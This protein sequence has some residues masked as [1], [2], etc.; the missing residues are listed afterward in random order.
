[1]VAIPKEVL[2]VLKA[3]DSIKVLASVDENGVPNAV[4]VGSITPISEDTLAFAEQ[5]I[6]HTK[7]NLEKT[8][9]ASVAILNQWGFSASGQMLPVAAY[10]LKGAFLGFQTSGPLFDNFSRRVAEMRARGLELPPLKSVG[11]IRV[12]EVFAASP[13]SNSQKLA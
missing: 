12:D 1:M 9:K 13:G 10:Q 5:F 3:Q 7:H 11:T 8:G 4:F 2:D 6:I